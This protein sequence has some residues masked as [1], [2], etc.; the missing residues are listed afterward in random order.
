M[1][2]GLVRG[3][4]LVRGYCS[5]KD[6]KYKRNIC[7]ILEFMNLICKVPK[8][9]RFITT[10]SDYV[11]ELINYSYVQPIHIGKFLIV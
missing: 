9:L 3:V 8:Y 4:L 10:F 1:Q 6:I 7:L 5:T 11:V 2:D